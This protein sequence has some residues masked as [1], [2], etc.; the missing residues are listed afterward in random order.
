MCVRPTDPPGRPRP[1]AVL[2]A[3]GTAAHHGLELG[4]GVGLVLQPE[5]GLAGSSVLWVAALGGWALAGV[6][7]RRRWDPV[8]DMA[9]GA[10]LA[11]SLVHFTLWP[12][13]R[14]RLGLPVLTEAEGMPQ[15]RLGAYNAVL[16][17]WGAAAGLSLLLETRPGHR[18]W[19]LVGAATLPLLRRSAR[20][21]F[22]WATRQAVVRPAWWNRALAPPPCGPAP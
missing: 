12:W 4:T 22:E 6:G 1:L 13:H 16:W 10:A 9:C 19:G 7:R 2:A 8:V 3:A 15:R 21:H 18:R 20:H 5:L 17:S 14:G 11:G